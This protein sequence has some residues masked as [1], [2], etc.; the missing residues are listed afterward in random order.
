[1]VFRHHPLG[2]Q[3]LAHRLLVAP[4]RLEHRLALPVVGSTA[5]FPLDAHDRH[6]ARQG[7]KIY[8]GLGLI[9]FAACCAS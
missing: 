1:M 5:M 4:R 3:R 9:P 6:S 2:S 7:H 8:I